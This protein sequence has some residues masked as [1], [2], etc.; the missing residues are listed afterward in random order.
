MYVSYYS[1][2]VPLLSYTAGNLAELGAFVAGE[3]MTTTSGKPI[4][5]HGNNF[6]GVEVHKHPNGQK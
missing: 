5:Q 6:W 1:A 4:T 3:G 2:G